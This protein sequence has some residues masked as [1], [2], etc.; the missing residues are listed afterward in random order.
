MVE[1]SLFEVTINQGRTTMRFMEEE[2]A[3]KRERR[4]KACMVKSVCGS[5]ALHLVLLLTA[6]FRHSTVS[7]CIMHVV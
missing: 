6:I 2:T 5:S 7:A 1:R 4:R 3:E